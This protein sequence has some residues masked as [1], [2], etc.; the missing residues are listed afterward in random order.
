MVEDATPDD[1]PKDPEAHVDRH[2][3]ER[4][5]LGEGGQQPGD[6][7]IHLEPPHCVA[8]TYVTQEPALNE[9]DLKGDSPTDTN[10]D[11]VGAPVREK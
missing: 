8:A 11:R 10:E 4:V 6:V 7:K 3:V 1:S 2:A 9:I 5:L